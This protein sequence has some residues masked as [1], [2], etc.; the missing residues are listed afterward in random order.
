[1]GEFA[2]I[3]GA[4]D[5]MF[6]HTKRDLRRELLT[7]RR[8]R[9]RDEREN[10]DAGVRATLVEWLRARFGVHPPGTVAAYVPMDG[11]PGGPSLVDVLAGVTPHVLL[12]I[13]LPDRDLDWAAHD[14]VA[15]FAPAALG[16]R[17]QVGPRLGPDA[18]TRA[19]VV[20][21]PA[22]A[23]DREG[24]RLGRGGG[25]YD[26]ALSRIR[27]AQLV[28]TLLYPDEVLTVVPAEPHDRPVHG[29]VTPDRVT[30]FGTGSG[31]RD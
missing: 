13:V 20:L 15:G 3:P 10:L 4:G 18:V 9:V 6:R 5:D 1:M 16:L 12:P 29:V 11:E 31:W 19:D 8:A 14:P 7:A 23:V 28:L 2:A 17:E 30:I 27:P 26:R 25:S 22:L 21:V 24:R